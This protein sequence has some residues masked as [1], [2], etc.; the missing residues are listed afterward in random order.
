MVTSPY[1]WKILE[2]NEKNPKQIKLSN[3]ASLESFYFLFFQESA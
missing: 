1:E 2:W 3:K